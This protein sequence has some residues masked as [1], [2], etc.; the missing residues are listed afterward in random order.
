MRKMIDRVKADRPNAII[1]ADM[2]SALGSRDL[3]TENL[4]NDFGVIFAGAQKNFGTSGLTFTL[5]RDDVLNRVKEVS[6]R[7]KY[8]VPVMMDW[9]KQAEITD[10]FVNTPANMAIYVSQLVTEHMLSKGGL[11]YYEN[12]ADKKSSLL[13]DFLDNSKDFI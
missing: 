1:V 5:V 4:W 9:T 11:K 13:Y 8:P 12:L 10:F 2:S 3:E 6:R 7:S